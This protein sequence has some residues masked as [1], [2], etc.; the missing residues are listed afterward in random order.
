MRHTCRSVSAPNSEVA[1]ASKSHAEFFK[2]VGS[3]F[4]APASSGLLAHLTGRA[5]REER[6]QARLEEEA[7]RRREALESAEASGD[8]GADL[9]NVPPVEADI[10]RATLSL[11]ADQRQLVLQL[12][13]KASQLLDVYYD[14]KWTEVLR[15]ENIIVHMRPPEGSMVFMRGETV[16]PF[17]LEHVLQFIFDPVEGKY[18]DNLLD[19]GTIFEH[20]PFYTFKIFT[21]FKKIL[22]VASRDLVLCAQLI[23]LRNNVVLVPTTSVDDPRYPESSSSVRAILDVGG[24]VL[25]PQPDG[26]T[27]G[28]FMSL[29][30]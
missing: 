28:V 20:N 17:A 3:W 24:W 11:P 19:D 7:R 8:Y 22:M 29:C 1:D 27:R 26:T 9:R 25:Y 4:G 5:Q 15:K 18:Y 6:R 21:K 12:R 13:A 2:C 30:D 14:E 16:F 23:R 10:E